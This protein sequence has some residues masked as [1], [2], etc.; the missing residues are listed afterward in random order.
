MDEFLE[1]LHI[2]ELCALEWGGPS[3]HLHLQMVCI[4]HIFNVLALNQTMKCQLGLNDL[5][6]PHVGHVIHSKLFERSRFAY[7]C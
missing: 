6:K 5:M 2:F 7:L 3:C 4:L 1:L